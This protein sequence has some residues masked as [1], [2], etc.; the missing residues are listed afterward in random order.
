MRMRKD[1]REEIGR[2]LREARLGRPG[3]PETQ[4]QVAE[5][6]GLSRQMINRYERGRD[7]PKAENLGKLL[8][9]YGI[10]INLP[11]YDYRLTAEALEVPDRTVP[12]L[13]EQ[14]S[15]ELDKSSV[16]TNA[17]VRILPKRN[18]IE[19]IISRIVVGSA[20]H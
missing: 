13:N 14:L 15:L 16:L 8:K 7:A 11:G 20:K 2:R 18:S 10:S 1:I 19:I 12:S 6:L 5:K 17:S 3:T 4:E 9:Y